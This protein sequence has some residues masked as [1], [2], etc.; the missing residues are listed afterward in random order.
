M[1]SSA[2]SP[3][4]VYLLNLN[5]VGAP[6]VGGGGYVNL[7]S[8]SPSYTLRF[9]IQGVSSICREGKLWI[10]IPKDGEAFERE[11][12]QSLPFVPRSFC[13]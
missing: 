6:D 8:P 1:A 12:F 10:N 2:A 5:D 4:V 3:P 9:A 7:P 13:Q 11:K